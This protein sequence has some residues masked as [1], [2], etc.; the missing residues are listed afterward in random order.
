M[1]GNPQGT[2]SNIDDTVHSTAS[3]VDGEVQG[4]LTSTPQSLSGQVSTKT[5]MEFCQTDQETESAMSEDDHE[6]DKPQSNLMGRAGTIVNDW[7]SRIMSGRGAVLIL[8]R[9]D[10]V[11]PL[12]KEIADQAQF[13]LTEKPTED[14]NNVELVQGGAEGPWSDLFPADSYDEPSKGSIYH[15]PDTDQEDAII[16]DMQVVEDQGGPQSSQQGARPSLED[17]MV[18]ARPRTKPSHPYQL[19]QIIEAR[20]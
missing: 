7:I 1:Q 5:G 8:P 9:A 3:S 12:V 6:S 18:S 15:L 4:V 10:P 2:V 17:V 20:G 19:P 13:S 14:E 11:I 16:L